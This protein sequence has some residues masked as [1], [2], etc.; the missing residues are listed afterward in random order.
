[1]SLQDEKSNVLNVILTIFHL[2]YFR[3]LS[4]RPVVTIES[5]SSFKCQG[6]YKQIQIFFEESQ[7][8]MKNL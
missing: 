3:T 6:F 8:F 4:E 2:E 5:F 1:M 7:S